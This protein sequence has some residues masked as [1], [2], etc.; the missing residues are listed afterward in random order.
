VVRNAAAAHDDSPATRIRAAGLPPATE[1]PS[2][3]LAAD[4]CSRLKTR[5]NPPPV[6]ESARELEFEDDAA[7]EDQDRSVIEGRAGRPVGLEADL[8]VHGHA[9]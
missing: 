5:T 7:V 4:A 6:R 2:T 8:A 3:Y 1:I 9:D